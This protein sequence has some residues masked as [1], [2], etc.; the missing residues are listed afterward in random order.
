MI[1]PISHP[2]SLTKLEKSSNPSSVRCSFGSVILSLRPNI[3]T[4]KPAHPYGMDSIV[5]IDLKNWFAKEIGA[6]VSVFMLMGNTLLEQLSAAAA[7]KS[8][9]RQETVSSTG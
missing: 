3:D 6:G 7:V 2:S 5:A 4:G 9:Y 1:I 8:R